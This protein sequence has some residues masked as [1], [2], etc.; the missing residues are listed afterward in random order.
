VRESNVA[1][2]ERTSDS[3]ERDTIAGFPAFLNPT[4]GSLHLDV[5]PYLIQMHFAYGQD[6]DRWAPGRRQQLVR[7][8]ES[9]E[10]AP[11]L[12]DRDTWF[13]AEEAVPN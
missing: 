2:R 11:D 13:D 10:I 6:S 1:Q 9:M 5:D 7:L 12:G 4:S 8:A 3:V